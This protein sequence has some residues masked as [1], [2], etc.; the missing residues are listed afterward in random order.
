MRRVRRLAIALAA[1]AF[2]I[3]GAT[4]AT[5]SEQGWRAFVIHTGSMT[6]HVP[7]GDLVIDRPAK[8]VRVGDIITFAKAPGEYTTHRVAAATPHG[9][10]T[11]GDANPSDDFGYV[12]PNQIIGRAVAVIPYGGYVVVF[13]SHPTGDAGVVLFLLAMWLAWDLFIGTSAAGV[14]L[15]AAEPVDGGASVA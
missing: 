3:G 5:L 12:Q 7:P 2:L 13:L 10:R 4:V 6:P 14:P 1:M 11:R 15:P 8:H 9:L